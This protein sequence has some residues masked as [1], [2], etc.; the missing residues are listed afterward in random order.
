MCENTKT[1]LNIV[2]NQIFYLEY[3]EI[4]IFHS[5]ETR[6]SKYIFIYNV[7]KFYYIPTF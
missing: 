4:G 1:S 6:V 5:F 7:S 2:A 3:V